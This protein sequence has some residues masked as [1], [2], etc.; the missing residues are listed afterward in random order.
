MLT[1]GLVFGKLQDDEEG[2]R[3]TSWN[4]TRLP[5]GIVDRLR[6]PVIVAPMLRVSGPELVIAAC[7][8]GA[9]A[10]FPAMNA[11]TAANLDGWLGR[12]DAAASTASQPVAP[13]CVNLVMRPDIIGEYLPCVV[14][15]RVEVVITSVGSPAPV[16]DAL[17][18]VGTLVLSDVATLQHAHKAVQAGAD[19]LVLL[20]AGSGGQTGWLNPFAFVRAVREF[21]DGPVV[22]AGGLSDGVALRA[23]LELGADLGC[24]GTKFIAAQES[25]ASD[26]YRRQLIDCS[27]DDVLL[28]RSFTGL[29]ANF[30]RPTVAAAGLDPEKLDEQVTPEIADAV[31]GGRG[32]GTGPKRWTDIVSAGHSVSG[33]GAVQ[34]AAQIVADLEREMNGVATAA[35]VTAP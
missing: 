34:T 21:F 26:H 19:G 25:S 16:L 8:A 3:M 14:D 10:A 11:R 28:T 12:M 6:V 32:D 9:M 33:V 13:H 15:H 20:S 2:G 24:I 5:A 1:Y 18:D 17:H 30:L 22:L 7:Q 4:K 31:Y 35:A 27:L 29:P 23:A